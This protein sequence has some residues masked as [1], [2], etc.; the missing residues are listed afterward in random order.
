MTAGL[1]KLISLATVGMIGYSWAKDTPEQI[2][3]I[4]ALPKSV[5]T[6]SEAKQIHRLISYDVATSD[7]VTFKLVEFCEKSLRARGRSPSNDFWGTPYRLYYKNYLYPEN[8]PVT[9]HAEDEDR[10]S[11][12]SAGADRQYLTTDDLVSTADMDALLDD[13]LGKFGSFLEEQKPQPGS[14]DSL[15]NLEQ[16]TNSRLK[17]LETR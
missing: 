13:M 14:E 15:R 11:V 9:L 3:R 4:I 2:K 1:V 5:L 8:Y 17:E 10:Y 16:E 6:L 12:F 7:S